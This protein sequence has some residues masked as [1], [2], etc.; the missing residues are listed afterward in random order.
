MLFSE[1]LGKRHKSNIETFQSIDPIT[2]NLFVVVK[3][4]G[5]TEQQGGVADANLLPIDRG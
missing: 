3:Q 1:C 5:Q 2:R 4:I